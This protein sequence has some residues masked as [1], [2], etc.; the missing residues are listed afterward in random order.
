LLDEL[1]HSC[2]LYPHQLPARVISQNEYESNKR[3]RRILRECITLFH[4]LLFA[5]NASYRF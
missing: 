4:N 2:L 5:E 1:L 3:N